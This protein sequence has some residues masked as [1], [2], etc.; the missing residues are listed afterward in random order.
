MKK[1]SY[2]CLMILICCSSGADEDQIQAQIDEAVSEALQDTSTTSTTTSTTIPDTTTTIIDSTCVDY[3]DGLLLLWD[4][5]YAEL[6]TI[7][8]IY[9]DLSYGTITY[10]DGANEFFAVNLRWEKLINEVNNLSPDSKNKRF[11]D[12]LIQTFNYIYESNNIAIKGLDELDADLIIRA[13]SLVDEAFESLEEAI[14]LIP[15]GT[16]YGMKNDC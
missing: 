3:A 16:I 13:T 4:E 2:F 6:E 12:K 10:S 1:I 5:L 11:H 15:G 14:T 7:S 9:T 8:S